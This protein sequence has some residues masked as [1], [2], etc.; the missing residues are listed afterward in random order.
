MTITG[1][2]LCHNIGCSCLRSPPLTVDWPQFT[3]TPLVVPLD[4]RQAFIRSAAV[5]L[6]AE[7]SRTRITEKQLM[8]WHDARDAWMMAEKLWGAKPEDV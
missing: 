7:L 1:C 8:G 3:G 6:F 4:H 5:A 2:P